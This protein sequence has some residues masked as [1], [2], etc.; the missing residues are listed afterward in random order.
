MELRP[1]GPLQWLMLARAQAFDLGYRV[2]A[3]PM[4]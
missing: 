3:Q 4:L 1:V 2:T